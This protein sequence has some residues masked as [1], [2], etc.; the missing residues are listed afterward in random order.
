MTVSFMNLGS[1]CKFKLSLLLKSGE[2]LDDLV[3]FDG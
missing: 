2:T 1:K 3:T